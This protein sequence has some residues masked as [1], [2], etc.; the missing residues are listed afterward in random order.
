MRHNVWEGAKVRLRPIR[1]DDWESF[2]NNDLDSEAARLCDH[3]H[4]PRSPEGTRAWTEAEAEE[5]GSRSGHQL[6]LAIESLDGVLAGTINTFRCDA[7]NGTF[8]YGLGLFREHWRKGYGS[9]AVRIVLGFFFGELRY[10]KATVYI[11]SFNEGSIGF[12]KRLG[13]RE[14]GRLRRMI[15]TGGS[16]HDMYVFGL[17][18]EEFGGKGF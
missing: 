11:Y 12:H 18:K 14:E 5:A 15:Y 4:A 9:D 10:Q 1:P 2:Y 13:F 3:I 8:S 16:Y 17:T 7:R 6:R